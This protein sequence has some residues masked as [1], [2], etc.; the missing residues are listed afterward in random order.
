MLVYCVIHE[1]ELLFLLPFAKHFRI[2]FS[3]FD[4]VGLGK[5][6]YLENDAIKSLS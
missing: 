3:E 5:W 6:F 4:I 1:R 2:R